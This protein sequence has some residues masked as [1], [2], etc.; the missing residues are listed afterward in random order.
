MFEER[1]VTNN[2]KPAPLS[3]D[4]RTPNG[5]DPIRS[6]IIERS[7]LI[8]LLLADKDSIAERKRTW[9]SVSFLILVGFA[10]GHGSV[11]EVANSGVVSG[12][13]RTWE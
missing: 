6:W 13:R 4:H 10:S 2:L 7:Q 3:R 8:A 5:N 9:P 11:V 1:A 12:R